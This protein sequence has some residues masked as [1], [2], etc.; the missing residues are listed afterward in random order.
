[1]TCAYALEGAQNPYLPKDSGCE[2]MLA[3]VNS[4]EVGCAFF[5]HYVGGSA[6]R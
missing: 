2:Y 4:I 1:M 5:V 3:K 6:G